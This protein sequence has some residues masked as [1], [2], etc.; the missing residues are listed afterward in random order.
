MVEQLQ[1][2][3]SMISKQLTIRF[4]LESCDVWKNEFVFP[5]ALIVRLVL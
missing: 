5:I 1:L 3:L 4:T 2:S